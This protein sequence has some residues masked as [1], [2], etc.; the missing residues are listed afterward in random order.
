MLKHLF[1]L[2]LRSFK[3]KKLYS[4][5]NLVSLGLSIGAAGVVYLFIKHELTFDKFHDNFKHIYRVESNV[6]MPKFMKKPSRFPALSYPLIEK[7]RTDIPSIKVSTIYFKDFEDDLVTVSDHQFYDALTYVNKEFFSLFS[8]RLLKGSMENLFDSTSSAVITESIAKKYFGAGDPIGQ[9]LSVGDREDKRDFTVTGVIEDAPDNSSLTFNILLPIRTYRYYKQYESQWTEYNYS[10]F[11]QIDPNTDQKTLQKALDKIANE[12]HRTLVTRN[13]TF[14]F[15]LT[16][17]SDMHWNTE[18][19]WERTGSFQNVKILSAIVLVIV[20][21]ACSNFIS[22]SLVMSTKRR[23]EVGI[24]KLLGADRIKLTKQFIVESVIYAF[25]SA[26]IGIV[27]VGFSMRF[28]NTLVNKTINIDPDLW[29]LMFIIL[30]IL[31]VGVL[32]GSYPSFFL[33]RLNPA[34]I[35]SNQSSVKFRFALV[36]ILVVIQFTIALFLGTSSFIM[37]KQMNY[38]NQKD[39]GFDEELVVALPTFAEGED[40]IRVVN[41][42]KTQASIQTSIISVTGCSRPFFQGLAR[43]GFDSGGDHKSAKAIS[44]D[45]DFIRTLN[46]QLIEGRN[47]NSNNNSDSLTVIINQTMANE[48]GEEILNSTFRWGGD[49]ESQVIGILKDFNFQSLEFP[50]E[51]L[52]LTMNRKTGYPSSI[53]IKLK[54]GNIDEGLKTVEDIFHSCNPNKPFEFSFLSLDIEKQYQ[55]YKMWTTIVSLSNLFATFIAC[56]GLFGLAGIN[57][58]NNYKEIGIRKVFGARTRDILIQ[59]IKKYLILITISSTIGISLSVFVMKQWIN[60]F[61]N[62]ISIDQSIY[63]YGI[64]FGIIVTLLSVGYHSVSAALANPV[65]S[66][67]N[68]T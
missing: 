45:S 42:F 7:I 34:T 13:D 5:I 37:T 30:I 50:I 44:V 39:L 57:A 61:A 68:E 12:L 52:F 59:S 64:L 27:I 15:S 19:P 54:P 31:F 24:R 29:D 33:S 51:P 53:L 2:S 65:D 4:L 35:L 3:T 20:I 16:R 21:L 38:I 32:A 62:R 43:M 22:L 66:I 41:K 1:K 14:N 55:S 10:F 36:P 63:L 28:F 6:F 17:L 58:S 11:V 23:V 25:V 47:F 46:L 56:I 26:V 67:R 9:I 60:N 48:L 18:M 8:F 40:A 49:Q